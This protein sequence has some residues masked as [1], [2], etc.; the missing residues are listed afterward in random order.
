[1]SKAL[2]ISSKAG[3][4]SKIRPVNK[5]LICDEIVDQIM[6]LIASGDLK[7][8][9][10]L[11]S[12][13]ELSKT[14]GASRSSLREALRCLSIVGVLTARVGEGT[15]VSLDGGKFLGKIIEWRV[16][17]ERHDIED[18]MEARIALECVTAAKAAR[19][20]NRQDL[21]K[22]DTILAKMKKTLDDPRR[23]TELDVEFHVTMAAASE[24]FLIY[25]LVSMIRGQ[26]EKVLARVLRLPNAR[27]ST[28]KEHMA[29]VDALRRGD[30]DAASLA[31]NRHLNAALNRYH[32]TLEGK[33]HP[34]P[35]QV[36]GIVPI[37][38]G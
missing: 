27:P 30:S 37:H 9:Q 25:D 26:L 22:F 19:R 15:S 38:R 35:R 21:D 6:S 3:I 32:K 14:F 33:E 2:Q 29:I 13:R 18:L 20:V 36:R 8:G 5:A 12:E 16:I 23:F 24:N 11:P 7:P 34:A 28:L 10:Q 4:Q 1:M 17:T 31:M